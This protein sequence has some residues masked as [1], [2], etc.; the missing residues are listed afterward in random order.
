MRIDSQ[1]WFRLTLAACL[2]WGGVAA[3]QVADFETRP[4]GSTPTDDSPLGLTETYIVGAAV[5]TMGADETGD[6][7]ADV[8]LIFEAAGDDGTDG[9]VRFEGQLGD[10]TQPGFESLLGD[11]FLRTEPSLEAPRLV[12]DYEFAVGAASGE[13]WDLDGRNNGTFEQWRITGYDQSGA[14]VDQTESPAGIDTSEPFD[15][16]PWPFLLLGD[17]IRKIVIEHIGTAVG[18]GVAFNNFRADSAIPGPQLLTYQPDHGVVDLGGVPEARFYW[19]EPVSVEP[20]DVLVRTIGGAVVDVPFDVETVG[21]VTTVTFTGE[22]GGADT[23]SPVPLHL[24]RYR[25]TIR[26]SARAVADNAPIDGDGDGVAGGDA[27]VTVAHTCG[28]DLAAEFGLL[29][30]S[31]INAFVSIF[32]TGC[33]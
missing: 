18:V 26:D 27:V 33:Q 20:E 21:T 19:S 17:G 28:A 9:F 32:I 16:E 29:D 8:P 5:F 23:G 14:V 30:L 6:N 7:I 12:I 3:G 25:V 10:T 13:I 11:W 31:D 15:G 22:P 4:N 1:A 24:D 2:A